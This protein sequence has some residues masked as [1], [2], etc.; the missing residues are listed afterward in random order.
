MESTKYC[1]VRF[2]HGIYYPESLGKWRFNAIGKNVSMF[3]YNQLICIFNA[4]WIHKVLWA[5]CR[6]N[7]QRHWSSSF[8]KG[9]PNSQGILNWIIQILLQ[10][11][12]QIYRK[13]RI[14]C[15]KCCYFSLPFF[16]FTVACASLAFLNG[17]VF[18]V[19]GHSTLPN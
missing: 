12:T 16:L 14:Y 11:A 5:P 10:E 18:S 6:V 7:G 19:L 2:Y 3:A 13:L 4:T 17:R 1:K 15:T 8:L 9:K